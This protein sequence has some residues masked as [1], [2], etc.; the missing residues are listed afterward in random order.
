[1]HLPTGLSLHILGLIYSLLP[2]QTFATGNS[3]FIVNQPQQGSQWVNGQANP[4]SWTKGLLDGVNSVDVEL[5][6]LSSDGLI[7]VASSVNAKTGS[8]NVLPQNV[9]P[10]DDYYLLFL[11]VSHGAMYA[12]SPRFS[13]LS[14]GASSPS[15]TAAPIAAAPTVTLSGGPNPTAAVFAT[16]FAALPNRGHGRHV[17]L[18]AVY[19]MTGMFGL[20]MTCLLGAIWTLLF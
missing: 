11:N 17:S 3:Y 4:I 13:I 2:L 18:D 1:M 14:A 9:P 12:L 7:Y 15:S 10:A 19:S 6:R 16:T 5:A 8:L 20:T